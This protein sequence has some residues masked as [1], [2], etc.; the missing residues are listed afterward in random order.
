MTLNDRLL[1]DM[2]TA[3]KGK[4]ETKLALSV[5]RMVRAAVKNAEIDKHRPLTDDEILDLLVREVKMR[6]DSADSIPVHEREVRRDFLNQLEAEKAIIR[7]YLPEP[8]TE[9][10]LRDAVADAIA[11]S[12]AATIKDMGRVMSALM[13]RVKGRAD[14]K[15]VN[16]LVKEMLSPKG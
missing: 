5:I 11:E 10:E 14:G 12:G 13:P 15:L 3:M 16:Q 7:T 6:Q 4:E 2:K 9:A 8:L 1:E